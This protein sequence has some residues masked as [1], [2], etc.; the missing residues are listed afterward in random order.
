ML[1]TPEL[2]TPLGPND[3]KPTITFPKEFLKRIDP[4]DLKPKTAAHNAA[5]TKSTPTKK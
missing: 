4:A 1:V 5:A 3:P 2:T